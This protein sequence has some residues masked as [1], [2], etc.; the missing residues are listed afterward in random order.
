[1]NALKS[2]ADQNVCGVAQSVGV[3]ASTLSSSSEVL[4]GTGLVGLQG[5]KSFGSRVVA[6]VFAP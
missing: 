6:Y 1:M 5:T 4:A 3:C 2:S